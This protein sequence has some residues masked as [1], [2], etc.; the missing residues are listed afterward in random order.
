MKNS[1]VFQDTDKNLAAMRELREGDTLYTAGYEYT[2][3]EGGSV[4]VDEFKFRRYEETKRNHTDVKLNEE[5]SVIPAILY[6]EKTPSVEIPQDI[7]MSFYLTEVDAVQSF[8]D[9][10]RQ[11]LHDC[12]Q[13]LAKWNLSAT[14]KE[15]G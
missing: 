11:V 9:G 6:K 7:S 12:D 4:V 8:R 2:P 14:R 13:W 15:Q 3:T 1:V 5:E 10:M